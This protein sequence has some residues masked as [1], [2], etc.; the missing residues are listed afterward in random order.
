LPSA[1]ELSTYPF[2]P[3]QV[4][5]G[6]LIAFIVLGIAVVKVYAEMHRDATLSYVTNTKPGT[7]DPEFWFKVLAFGL[8]PLAGL[9]TRVFPQNQ[10][11][12]FFL[13]ST[14]HFFAEIAVK[15]RPRNRPATCR[16]TANSLTEANLSAGSEL[17]YLGRG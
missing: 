14:Q 5:S 10:R 9:L 1:D 16:Q 3:R 17:V 11:F 13:G 8:A 12:H 2:D 7:L 4:L 6:I 15:V